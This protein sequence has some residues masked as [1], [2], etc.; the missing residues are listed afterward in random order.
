[1]QTLQTQKNPVSSIYSNVTA[2]IDTASLDN[3]EMNFSISIIYF[4]I[5]IKGLPKRDQSL[6]KN[7]RTLST[8]LGGNVS[9]R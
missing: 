9:A 3:H 6:T 2:R 4:F 8:N 5:L 7:M 1:M